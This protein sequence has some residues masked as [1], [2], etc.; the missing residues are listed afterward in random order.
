MQEPPACVPTAGETVRA[1]LLLF[2]LWQSSTHTIQQYFASPTSRKVNGSLSTF[3]EYGL[4]TK[5][6]GQVVTD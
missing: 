6:G 2:Y 5:D 3:P 1:L 4:E